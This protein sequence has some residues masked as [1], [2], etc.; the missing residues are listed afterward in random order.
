MMSQVNHILMIDFIK[1]VL[2]LEKLF[3]YKFILLYQLIKKY[4]RC[5]LQ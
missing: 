2:K 1:S 5:I 3:L 4:L